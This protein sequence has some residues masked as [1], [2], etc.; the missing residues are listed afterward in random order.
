MN[1]KSAIHEG[2][3][4]LL[5]EKVVKENEMR[6]ELMSLPKSCF[7]VRPK[8]IKQAFIKEVRRDNKPHCDVRIRKEGLGRYTM[9]SKYRPKRHETTMSITQE[10]YES[11]W[12][13]SHSKQIKDRYHLENGWVVD[14][15]G[16]GRIVAEYEFKTGEREVKIPKD[17]KVK[18]ILDKGF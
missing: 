6:V 15:M 1:L 3:T 18:E 5:S 13:K 16:E 8:R 2:R 11:L 7:E 10:M 9:T 17:F 4:Y 12:K 14:L